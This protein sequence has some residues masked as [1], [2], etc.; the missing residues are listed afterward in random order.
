[1]AKLKKPYSSL[2][3]RGRWPWPFRFLLDLLYL[4]ILYFVGLCI[5][6]DVYGHWEQAQPAQVI[7]IMGAPV[8]RNGQPGESLRVRTLKAVSL[9]RS[10]LAG[11]IICTGGRGQFAPAQATAAAEMARRDGVRAGDLLLETRSQN[12]QQNARNAA[13][14]CRHHGWTQV[15]AVS[16]P[17]HLW[18]VNCDFAAEGINV[19]TSPARTATYDTDWRARIQLSAREATAVTRD[20]ALRAKE[21]LIIQ[22]PVM[23]HHVQHQLHAGKIDGNCIL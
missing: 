3:L 6:I 7:V 14:I 17:Y 15:I 23:L 12:T 13:A 21:W 1:M 8:Q 10:H 18:R 4:A 2:K 9:Y 19:Y 11:K 20:L 5:F 22:L 16:E